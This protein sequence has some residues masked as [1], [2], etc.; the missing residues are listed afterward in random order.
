VRYLK[1]INYKKIDR[2]LILDMKK[3]VNLCNNNERKKILPLIEKM[4]KRLT[5]LRLLIRKINEFF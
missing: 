1:L 4:D 3:S 2:D 5:N